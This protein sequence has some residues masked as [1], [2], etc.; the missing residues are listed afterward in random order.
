ML[1]YQ[2]HFPKTNLGLAL[3]ENSIYMM[4]MCPVIPNN[5]SKILTNKHPSSCPASYQ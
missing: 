3:K 1:E 2:N 5:P 4:I